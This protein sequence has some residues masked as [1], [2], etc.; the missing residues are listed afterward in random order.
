MQSQ[1]TFRGARRRSLRKFTPS[2]K[3]NLS[4]VPIHA[5]QADR[6][7]EA[8][9]EGQVLKSNITRRRNVLAHVSARGLRCLG[10]SDHF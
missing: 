4:L 8:Q 10:F 5:S 9:I 3:R 7:H 2:P 1:S 6:Q